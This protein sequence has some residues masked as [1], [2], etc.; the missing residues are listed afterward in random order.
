[1]E[2]KCTLMS[3]DWKEKIPIYELNE[4]IEKVFDG[5]NCPAI[6]EPNHKRWDRHSVV[7][8]SRK[9]S[10]PQVNDAWDYFETYDLDEYEI[11]TLTF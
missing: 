9:L 3:W 10:Q 4:K 2:I 7:I 6:Q 8:S 1:M 11:V 5:K